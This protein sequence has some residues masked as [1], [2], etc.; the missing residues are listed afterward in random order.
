MTLQLPN[1]MSPLHGFQHA[2]QELVQEHVDSYGL[3]DDADSGET[4]AWDVANAMHDTLVEILRE[5]RLLNGPI[6][7]ALT[8]ALEEQFF[9]DLAYAY[10]N[11]YGETENAKIIDMILSENCELITLDRIS[12]VSE[13][14]YRGIDHHEGDVSFLQFLISHS[15]D[16]QK[17]V[18]RVENRN[19]A[20]FSMTHSFTIQPTSHDI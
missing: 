8:P 11:T 4:H 19:E 12:K 10:L 17:A 18:R 1:Y 3:N 5:S 15:P 6:A 20:M 16:I 13:E 9:A 2:L 14:Y 7:S